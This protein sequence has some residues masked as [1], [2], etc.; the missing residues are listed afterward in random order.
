[1]RYLNWYRLAARLKPGVTLQQ[2]QANVTAIALRLAHDFPKTNGQ[3]G[4]RVA[5]Y[6]SNNMGDVGSEM[7]WLVMVLSGLVL[8]IACV[9]LANLQLVRTTRRSHE[10]A[11]RLALG[12]SRGR[13]VAMLLE[14][15][16][17]LS[18]GGALLA[19]LVGKWSNIYVAKY[20]S[21][22][23]PLDLR[24]IAFTFAAA[25][26][27]GAVFGLIP[28]WMASREDVGASLKSAGRGSTSGRARHWFRQSLVV[29]ELVLALT[30]LKRRR[31]FCER[32][33]QAHPPGPGMD[34]RPHP[35]G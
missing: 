32:D 21:I 7:T 30:V 22:D 10:I 3:R 9:N 35:P 14:E 23:M 24:V 16:F 11:I 4:F 12:S 26:L 34:R 6:P 8:V 17:I 2:A 33:L 25:S 19:L 5:A 18:I 28:A 27:T 1:M 13:I 31:L 29:V 15:S 20:F